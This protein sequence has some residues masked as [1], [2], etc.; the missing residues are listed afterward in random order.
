MYDEVDEDKY[1]SIVRGRLQRDD[2]VVDD[3]VDG[4]MDNGMEDWIEED[5]EKGVSE[6]EEK[7]RKKKRRF[8][9]C[10]LAN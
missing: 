5:G 8:L 6:D 9:A 1:K 4:Y 3:G 7:G 10:P 2:F